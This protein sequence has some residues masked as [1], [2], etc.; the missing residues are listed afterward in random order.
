MF[1]F[2]NNRTFHDNLT[3]KTKTL[4]F[5]YMHLSAIFKTKVKKYLPIN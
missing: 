2:I 4:F 1:L 5:N 3:L